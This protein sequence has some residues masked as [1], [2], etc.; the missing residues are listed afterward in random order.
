MPAMSTEIYSLRDAEYERTVREP[1]RLIIQQHESE[2]IEELDLQIARRMRGLAMYGDESATIELHKSGATSTYPIAW[3]RLDAQRERTGETT[4]RSPAN[5]QPG[6]AVI[7][8]ALRKSMAQKRCADAFFTRRAHGATAAQMT[9]RIAEPGPRCV[10]L[11]AAAEDK[12]D[13]EEP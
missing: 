4:Q 1:T 13:V 3:E 12:F 8:G 7:V 9:N 2:V 10:A 6:C 11:R 5:G